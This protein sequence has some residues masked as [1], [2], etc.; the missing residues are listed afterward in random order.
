MTTAKPNPLEA[1]YATV[2][3]AIDISNEL[4]DKVHLRPPVLDNLVETLVDQRDV[5]IAKADLTIILAHIKGLL[6]TY[7][8]LKHL[9]T[10]SI[11]KDLLNTVAP[12]VLPPL[13]DK[14]ALQRLI[15]S[16]Y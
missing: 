4:Q 15:Q 13:D 6:V 8:F 10:R 7:P 9:V 11:Q 12:C 3:L 16:T 14:P 2:S 1:V 5:P